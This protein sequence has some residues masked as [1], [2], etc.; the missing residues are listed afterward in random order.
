M[1]DIDRNLFVSHKHED[2]DKVVRL[3]ENLGSR[4]YNVRDYS[5]TKDN[6]NKAHN[7]DY[8]KREILKPRLD[9]S[10]VLVVI[11]TP[12]TKNSDYVDWEI[13]YAAKH[14][15]RIVGVWGH[16]S[17]DCELPE[18]LEDNYD[19]LVAWD[20]DK[21]IRAIEG[22]N[23]NEEEDGRKRPYKKMKPAPCT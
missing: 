3:K 21:I 18:A 11:V 23:F 10:S 14:N 9:A 2:D 7:E 20:T 12:D 4:D 8:I 19:S 17:K 1:S 15:K 5:V 16:G 22:E 13:E 6:P